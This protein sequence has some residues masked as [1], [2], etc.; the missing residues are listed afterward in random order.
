MSTPS[1]RKTANRKKA[2]SNLILSLLS[3]RQIW[4]L[5]SRYAEGRDSIADLA[6]RAECPPVLLYCV[7][8]PL[9]SKTA[10]KLKLLRVEIKVEELRAQGRSIRAIAE[11]LQLPESD[12]AEHADRRYAS[13]TYLV[14]P[15]YHD[16]AP[17]PVDPNELLYDEETLPPTSRLGW[18]DD[19]LTD[20][21]KEQKGRC[22]TCGHLVFLPCLACRVRHD[23][24]TKTIPKAPE[25]DDAEDREE[26]E[27][28]LLFL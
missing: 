18:I 28:E 11:I 13:E 22:P 3:P 15:W 21:P 5:R 25:Y 23:M 19:R 10:L 14:R 24:A 7:L 8:T 1:A 27:P 17:R 16:R 4:K 9:W 20:I 26:R 6:E 2:L 12:I